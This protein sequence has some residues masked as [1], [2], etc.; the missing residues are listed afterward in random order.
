MQFL[1]DGVLTVDYS[2]GHAGLEDI[3]FVLEPRGFELYPWPLHAPSSFESKCYRQVFTSKS[4]E[5]MLKGINRR[6]D[7][8]L[9]KTGLWGF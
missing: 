8:R 6:N 1:E 7:L 9:E 4:I 2:T 3:L 5:K